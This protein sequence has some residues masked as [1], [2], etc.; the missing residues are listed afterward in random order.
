[1]RFEWD[2]EKRRSNLAKHRV[3]FV[4]AVLIVD[5][6]VFETVDTRRDY[7]ETRIRC[8]GEVDGR[9]YAVVYTWRGGNRRIITA[10]KANARETRAYSARYS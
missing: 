2:G 6:P 7:R 5:G 3:D 10:R 1:M 9:V 8:L 4:R